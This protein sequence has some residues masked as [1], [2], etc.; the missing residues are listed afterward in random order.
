[1]KSLVIVDD[2]FKDPMLV[3]NLALETSYQDVT[4]LNYPG[5]QSDMAFYNQDII[6][7]FEKLLN[8]EID[9]KVESL[10]FGKFRFM[11]R[12]SGSRIKIHVDGLAEWT[13]LIY[14]NTPDQCEGGTAFYR[15][16]DTGLEGP[17]RPDQ[18]KKFGF[19]SVLDFEQRI[20]AEQSLDLSRWEETTF[21]GMRFNR[22]VLFRGNELF[23]CHTHGFGNTNENAR[24]TQNFSLTL[25]AW[26]D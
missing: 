18:M 23:H 4:K 20:I 14:L 1:M 3:R 21:V 6:K 24:L 17:P 13:G 12:E 9:P 11:T 10:T 25:N 7:R 8:D 2:F 5:L 19:E 22:L 16:I 15:H 26:I